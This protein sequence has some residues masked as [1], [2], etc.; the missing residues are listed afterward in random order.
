MP[1]DTPAQ[2]STIDVTNHPTKINDNDTILADGIEYTIYRFMPEHSA[3]ALRN[4]REERRRGNP[5]NN[6]G[7]PVYVGIWS[8]LG[9][10]KLRCVR[11]TYDDDCTYMIIHDPDDPEDIDEV[12][13]AVEFVELVVTRD[14]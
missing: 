6:D 1:S 7:G 3:A 9:G 2:T 5:Y 12:L 8:L 14:D 10:G 4:E 11:E 13:E